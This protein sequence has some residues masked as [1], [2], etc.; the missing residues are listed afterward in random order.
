MS[1]DGTSALASGNWTK[2]LSGMGANGAYLPFGGGARNC[3][4]T[5]FALMEAKL[6]LATILQVGGPAAN[7]LLPSRI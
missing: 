7:C 1:P 3:I 2:A 4:G 5:G 6:V